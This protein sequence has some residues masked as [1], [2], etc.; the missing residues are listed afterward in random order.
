MELYDIVQR[1]PE[2][3][4]RCWVGIFMGLDS[5]TGEAIVYAGA[6][7]VH[8]DPSNLTVIGKAKWSPNGTP[9]TG[10]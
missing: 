4:L 6:G 5:D 10:N 9:L 7:M 8:I 2:D 1:I 3:G